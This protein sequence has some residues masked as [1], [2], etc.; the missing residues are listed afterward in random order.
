MLIKAGIQIAGNETGTTHGRPRTCFDPS[1]GA[2]VALQRSPVLP[3]REDSI[4]RAERGL[5]P[6]SHREAAHGNNSTTITF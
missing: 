6:K 1:P 5:K 3:E 4:A 2:R